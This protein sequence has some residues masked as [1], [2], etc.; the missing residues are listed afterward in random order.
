[1][2]QWKHFVLRT[3]GYLDD[4]EIVSEIDQLSSDGWEL[5]SVTS[6]TASGVARN[7]PNGFAAPW[8]CPEHCLIFK[9]QVPE[10]A[11]ATET[12]KIGFN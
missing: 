6:Y 5:L 9:K 10:G 12:R 8:S 11:A 1:M 7:N 4:A 2:T 3:R